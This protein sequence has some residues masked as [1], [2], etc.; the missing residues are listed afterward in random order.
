MKRVEYTSV[1]CAKKS[2]AMKSG[3][4]KSGAM[5]SGAR[6]WN[7]GSWIQINTELCA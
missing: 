7:L 1:V 5:K 4:M 6:S 2:G 3:A